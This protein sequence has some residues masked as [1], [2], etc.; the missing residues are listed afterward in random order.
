[1][2][3]CREYALKVIT[4][5]DRTEKEIREKLIQKGYDEDSIEETTEFLKNYG[6]INDEKYASSFI[7]D[8]I[9]LKKWGKIRVRTELIKRG[10]PRDVFENLLEEAFPDGSTEIICTQIKSRFKNCDLKNQKERTRIFNFFLRRG[11]QAD[12]IKSA[13]NDVCSFYDIDSEF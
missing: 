1:M 9:N 7:N 5:R 3:D 4:F 8:A 13:L 2:I 10:V 11:Y 6:Y 12:E